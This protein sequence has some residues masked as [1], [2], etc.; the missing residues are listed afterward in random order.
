MQETSAL[1]KK[2]IQ[3]EHWFETSVTIGDSG[4]LVTE[5][6]DVI[7]F[8]E[9]PQEVTSILVD[10]GGAESGFREGSL[11]SVTTKAPFFKD[12]SP[13]VGTAVSGTVNIEMIAPFNVPKRGRICIYTRAVNDTEKS[14]W[15]QCGTYYIDTRKQVHDER[16]FDVLTLEG[17]DAMLLAEVTYPSDKS[18]EKDGESRYPMLDKTMVKFIADNMKIDPNGKNGI[19]VDPRTWELMTAGYK[20]NLPAGYSMR[21]A[22]GMIAASYAG[23]FIISPTGELRLVS[24]FDLPPETRVLCTEDGYKI[25]FGKTADGENVYILV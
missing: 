10:T 19:S 14:E 2:I 22:L 6:G 15:L 3:G 21:E 8:G 17:Y 5:S 12:S 24:M 4:R 1:Y 23:N 16:G 11:F 18:E 20:F 9:A 7:T 13:C 25:V